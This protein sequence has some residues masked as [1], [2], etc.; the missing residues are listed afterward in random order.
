MTCA[1]HFAVPQHQQADASM[2]RILVARMRHIGP[3]W[4]RVFHRALLAMAVALCALATGG[5]ARADQIGPASG[6]PVP[7]YVSLKSDRVNLR[8]GPSKD[9]RTVWVFQRAG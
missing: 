2:W 9:H 1:N 8:E 7:R 6:L 4:N 3:L 5:T